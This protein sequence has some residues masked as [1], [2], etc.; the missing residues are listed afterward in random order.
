MIKE[1]LNKIPPEK[2][3]RLGEKREIPNPDA[4]VDDNGEV[5]VPKELVVNYH[6]PID[7]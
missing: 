3:K 2:N 5:D 1:I 4:L 7:L 6:L